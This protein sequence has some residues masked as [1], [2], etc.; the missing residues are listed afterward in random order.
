MLDRKEAQDYAKQ[1]LQQPKVPYVGML[2]G[3]TQV[4]AMD[5]GRLL[6]QQGSNGKLKHSIVKSR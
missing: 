6:V 1:V 4:F 2:P 3:G 5:R